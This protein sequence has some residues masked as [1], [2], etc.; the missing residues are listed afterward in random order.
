MKI[1]L[2]KVML[3]LYFFSVIFGFLHVLVVGFGPEVF[4]VVYILIVIL[5]GLYLLRLKRLENPDE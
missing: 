5:V 2:S 3:C 1:L 4:G